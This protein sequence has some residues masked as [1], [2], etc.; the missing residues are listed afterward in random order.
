MLKS[1]LGFHFCQRLPCTQYHESTEAWVNVNYLNQN[2]S[3]C[4]TKW[5]SFYFFFI[6]QCQNWTQ[7]FIP[8][9]WNWCPMWL[10]FICTPDNKNE[11][12]NKLILCL[13]AVKQFIRGGWLVVLSISNSCVSFWNVIWPD[14]LSG[15]VWAKIKQCQVL[16]PQLWRDAKTIRRVPALAYSWN[17]QPLWMW[18]DA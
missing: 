17:Y 14:N 18:R 11:R 13:Q 7:R 1:P 4:Q 3:V 9:I 12:I 10:V 8:E 16:L 2:A 6:F 15:Y 5:F